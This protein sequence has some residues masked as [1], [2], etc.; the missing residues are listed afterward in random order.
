MKIRLFTAVSLAAGALVIAVAGCGGNSSQLEA[1]NAAL[2]AELAAL[3]ARADDSDS[4]REA[5]ARRGQ[6]EAQEVARLRGELTQ[7]RT[8]AKDAEKLR[9]ENQQLRNE[10]QQL[11]GGAKAAATPQPQ[12][13]PAPGTFP[14]EAWTFSGYASPE[15]AL[16]SAIWSMQQGN[17]RQYFESLS[18]DEQLRMAKSWEGKS[19]DE[20]VAK[21][22]S[23]TAKIT[24]LKVLSQQAVSA[25]EVQ[26]NVHIDGV[27]RTE[28]VTMKRVGEE[29]RFGGFIREPKP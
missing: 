27:D 11:R 24:G 13:Q 22:Q 9:S 8:T 10:N 1:E 5:Q 18:Q 15:A 23:D 19:Q 2:R 4:A 6:S 28:K 20:I 26:M 29:W 21:H 25:D 3:K 7:L 17:P 12:P 14:R 16:V